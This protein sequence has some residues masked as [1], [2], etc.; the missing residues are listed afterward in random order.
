MVGKFFPKKLWI[1]VTIS[2]LLIIL[3]WVS[4]LTN[5]TI[6][7]IFTDE[8]IYLRWA[9]IALT[10]PKWR[11]ISLIDGKQ[12]LFIWLLLPALKIIRD[13]LVA[14]RLVSII[15]GFVGF[16]GMGVL[17]FFASKS[18]KGFIVG[19]LL[20][21]LIPFFLLYDRLAIY[22]ALF[23]AISIWTLIL[24]YLFAKKQSLGIALVLGSVIGAGLLTKSYAYFFLGLLPV[25]GLIIPWQKSRLKQ[26]VSSLVGLMLAVMVQALIY[27]NLTRLSEFRHIIGQKNLSF[28]YSLSEFISHPFLSFYGNLVGLLG[29]LVGWLTIPLSVVVVIS[30][31]WLFK[32]DIR[33]GL[34]FMSFFIIPLLALAFFGKVIYPRFLLFMIPTLLVPVI[35]LAVDTLEKKRLQLFTAVLMIVLVPLVYFDYFLLTN[36]IHA[37]IP[38]ADRQQFISDWPAGYGVAEIVNYLQQESQTRHVTL[39]MEGTFGLFPMAFE[40]YLKDNPNVTFKA[41]WPVNEIPQEM[42]DLAQNE[43]V[44]FVFKEKQE[45]PENWPLDFVNQYQRG[46]APSYMKFYRVLPKT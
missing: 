4:R 43:P 13:P 39:G 9:Q 21:L 37:P 32:R 30:Y 3:Y 41:Y 7:P 16:I 44:Y 8:A 46:D 45:I 23:T 42:V 33:K 31:I 29:W 19:S 17:G 15:L 35:I 18:W 26:Q 5:L 10:D 34:F 28:V 12:P 25:T 22:E 40:L 20:Y 38:S 36:P 1:I 2:I 6:I 11:F 14:G 24:M 27:E